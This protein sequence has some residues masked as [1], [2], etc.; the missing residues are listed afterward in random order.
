MTMYSEEKKT[1]INIHYDRWITNVKNFP[2][3][4]INCPDLDFPKK[5]LFILA[6]KTM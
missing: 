3:C 2:K 5:P 1:P 4:I 6:I